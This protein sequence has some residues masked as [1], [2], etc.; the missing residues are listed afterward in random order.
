MYRPLSTSLYLSLLLLSVCSLRLPFERRALSGITVSSLKKGTSFAVQ[1]GSPTTAT[2][3]VNDVQD[4][5][6]V[7]NITINGVEVPVALDT[8]STD[9]WVSP[10]SGV[11]QFQDTGLEIDLTYGNPSSPLVIRGT[12]GV[13]P[14]EFGSYKI[15]KQA[16]LNAVPSDNGL[17]QLGIYGLM[18][19]SFDLRT[20]SPIQEKI[21]ETQGQSAT[22]GRSVL[23]NIFTQN[24]TEPNMI[25]LLLAR[26]DDL[27]GTDG[28]SFTIGEY[29]PQY[30]S[31]AT[32]KKLAQFPKGYSRW[33]VLMDGVYVDDAALNLP[34]VN[35]NVPYGQAQTL[36]DTGNPTAEL[37]VKLLNDIY[38]RIPGSASYS[39][40]QGNFWVVPCDTVTNLEFSFAG[41]R[42]PVHPLDLSTIE[43]FTLAGKQY[44]ACISAFQSA[45][46]EDFSSNGFDVALGDSFLRNSAEDEDFSSNGFDVA[47]GDSFLRNVYSIFN[48]GD[49][50]V[51]GPTSD[52]FIQL[53][54]TLDHAKAITEV[55]TIRR[56]TLSTLPPEIDPTKLVG[57]LSQAD[58]EADAGA[59]TTS[60]ANDAYVVDGKP[61]LPSAS[62]G[63]S[64]SQDGSVVDKYGP[65][66]V[67]LLAANLLVLL[68]LVIL[69]VL[70]YMRRGSSSKK[71]SR[72]GV[73]DS[74]GAPVYAPVKGTEAEEVQGFSQVNF[75]RYGS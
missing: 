59:T 43:T 40:G 38:S 30:A 23:K 49:D 42:Y 66:I 55:T 26:T 63:Q 2:Q 56:Q 53:L 36:L 44:T 28:G 60:P 34:S 5:R 16:F 4:I 46:D 9:L 20:S 19:L 27:E 71:S 68:V 41:V 62:N 15:E 31:V 17:Q 21:F 13:A 29:L 39:G 37:P 58:S 52:S 7:T 61:T 69:A 50:L 64:A 74:T 22:W 72:R 25:A 57:M 8:G 1:A 14:F 12:I 11:G 10:P 45:E 18:G 35:P 65:I 73:L 3:D 24:P 32:Q 70:S 67:A 47:L 6:Y 48:F 54:S 51:N 75:E 33:T